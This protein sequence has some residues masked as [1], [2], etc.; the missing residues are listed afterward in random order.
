M[1]AIALFVSTA[2]A[3]SALAL[4]YAQAHLWAGVVLIAGLGAFWLFGQRRGWRWVPSLVLVLFV[5]AAVFG[6]GL[7]AE[8]IWM[9]LG[10]VVG[11]AAWDLDHFAQRMRKASHVEGVQNLE[12]RHLLRLLLVSGLGFL[13]SAAA[14]EVR[15]ELPMGTALLLGLLAIMGLSRAIRFLRRESD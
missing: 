14:L 8:P 2:L 13:L 12:R 7:A 1:S 5:S 11:L 6:L 10:V 3:A 4:G 15:V 9:L